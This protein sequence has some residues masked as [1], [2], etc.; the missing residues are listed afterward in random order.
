[1]R[2]RFALSLYE[3]KKAE[4]DDFSTMG[5]VGAHVNEQTSNFLL[6]TSEQA[7]AAFQQTNSADVG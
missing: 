5:W 4:E 1:M 7:F 6:I 3:W 2:E